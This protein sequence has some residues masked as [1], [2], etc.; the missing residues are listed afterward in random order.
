MT[1][2]LF[3]VA[4][5]AVMLMGIAAAAGSAMAQGVGG[6]APLSAAGSAENGSSGG[7][8]RGER[9]GGDVGTQKR[10]EPQS[11]SSRPP[12]LGSPNRG[13]SGY[14]RNSI[15][16]TPPSARHGGGRS[17]IGRGSVSRDGAR[18]GG[19]RR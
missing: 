13:M 2:R 18:S 7:V 6:D 19:G 3:G 14:H 15:G 10:A 12:S 5:S 16:T 8:K 9:R 11:G 1:K 17:S 4:V